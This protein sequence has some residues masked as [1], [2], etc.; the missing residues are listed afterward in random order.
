MIVPGKHVL[1]K[2]AYVALKCDN[3]LYGPFFHIQF[4]TYNA[5]FFQNKILD[6]YYLTTV[7]VF[8]MQHSIPDAADFRDVSVTSVQT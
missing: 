8:T 5:S 4:R 3:G 1:L 2:A 6:T 7:R